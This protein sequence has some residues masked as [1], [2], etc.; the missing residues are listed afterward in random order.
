MNLYALRE[1]N[2]NA[3]IIY[4]ALPAALHLNPNIQARVLILVRYS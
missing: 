4:G 1:I 3:E 2:M